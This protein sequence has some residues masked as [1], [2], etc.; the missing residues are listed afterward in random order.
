MGVSESWN[1]FLKRVARLALLPLDL[2][3]QL[4]GYLADL[5]GDCGGPLL[6]F[7]AKQVGLFGCE[8]LA[9]LLLLIDPGN[10]GPQIG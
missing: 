8:P 10:K 1:V 9:G 5:A 3:A 7:A 2:N 6:G 4:G